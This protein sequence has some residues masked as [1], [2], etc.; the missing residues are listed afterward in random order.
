MLSNDTVFAKKPQTAYLPI[1]N[2][3]TYLQNLFNLGAKQAISGFY[4]L[5][6]LNRSTDQ[7]RAFVK[8]QSLLG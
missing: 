6:Q 1:E 2:I 4:I 3:T 8:G 7:L 5:H